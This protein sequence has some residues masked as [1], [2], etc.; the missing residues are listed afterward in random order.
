MH[1]TPSHN[2]DTLTHA[3]M[4]TS[5][6]AAQKHPRTHPRCICGGGDCAARPKSTVTHVKHIHAHEQW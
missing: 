6:H 2:T 4:K 5:A 3:P 1:N